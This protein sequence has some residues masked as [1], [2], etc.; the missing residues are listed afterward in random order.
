MSSVSTRQTACRDCWK[1]IGMQSRILVTLACRLLVFLVN[2]SGG[3]MRDNKVANEDNGQ[4]RAQ[5]DVKYYKKDFWSTENLNYSA[6]HF[7]MRKVARTVSRLVGDR[8]CDL[9]D[10]GCGPGT[11][12][13]LMPANVHYHGIDIAIP[14]PGREPS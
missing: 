8:E 10:V 6:P 1:Y 3:E 4:A 12:Q 7:R 2:I 11:M 14:E 9:L 5:G 13:R